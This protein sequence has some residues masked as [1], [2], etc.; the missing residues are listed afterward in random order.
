MR[1][2]DKFKKTAAITLPINIGDIIL[3]GKFKNKRI[4]VK[5][6]GTDELGQP[7]INKDRKLLS[8][9]IEKKL[10]EGMWSSKTLAEKYKEKD[11][12]KESAL[13]EVYDSAFND[14]LEKIGR[15]GGPDPKSFGSRVMGGGYTKT[16]EQRA[17]FRKKWTGGLIGKKS[18]NALDKRM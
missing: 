6:I 16:S 10:P 17:K 1:Y 15:E 11:M 2:A 7:I 5:S 14:E 12:N 3:G 4:E 13:Q 9:R 18:S 8:V